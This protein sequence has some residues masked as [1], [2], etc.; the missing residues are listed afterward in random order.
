[1][2]SWK[3]FSPKNHPWV[4]NLQWNFLREWVLQGW[5]YILPDW[6]TV[7]SPIE[8]NY[9]KVKISNSKLNHLGKDMFHSQRR[10]SQII[11]LTSR[12]GTTT[13]KNSDE[14]SSSGVKIKISW[15]ICENF[16]ACK[17]ESNP[18]PPP[19]ME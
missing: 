9:N 16:V 12:V 4:N 6:Y 1:M 18:V 10:M 11:T 3:C 8:S 19:Y 17:I 15:S 14:E 2:I 7:S 13:E 5:P